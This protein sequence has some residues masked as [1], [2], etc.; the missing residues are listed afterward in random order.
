MVRFSEKFRFRLDYLTRSH[1]RN[2]R[3]IVVIDGTI[4]YL[5]SANITDY[6]V[7]WRELIIRIEGKLAGVF[8]GVF[9]S[10]FGTF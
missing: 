3:K 6:N 2:H 8:K 7:V 1:R 5:G 4:L 9:L 10:M